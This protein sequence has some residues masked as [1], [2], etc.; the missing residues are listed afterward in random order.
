MSKKRI[1]FVHCY[2][3]NFFIIFLKE[4]IS[5]NRVNQI[6]LYKRIKYGCV[7]LIFKC[8]EL[9]LDVRATPKLVHTSN[10]KKIES[11]FRRPFTI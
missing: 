7:K 2:V 1:T 10:D 5:I 4:R 8:N 6:E 11:Q 3:A 9:F